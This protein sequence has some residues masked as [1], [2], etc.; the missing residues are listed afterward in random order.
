MTTRWNNASAACVFIKQIR[1]LRP[2]RAA[3]ALLLLGGALG[4]GACATRPAEPPNLSHA[5]TAVLAYVDSGAYARE[6]AAVA[7]EAQAWIEARAAAR[8]PGERLAVVLDID[9]TVLSNLPHLRAQDFGYVPAV[10]EAW[11]ERAEAPALAPMADLFRAARA[12]DVAVLFL[13]GRRD[14]VERAGTEANLRAVGLGDYAALRLTPADAPRGQ[15]ATARKSA[16]RA[17]WA[18]E[19][20]TLIAAIGDQH[21][22]LG[23]PAERSFKLPNPFYFLP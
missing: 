20:W 14:P 8:R 9:E 16:A 2:S 5:K 19:G 11:V 6:F 3:A 22:D 10:W 7:A 13:T 1:R 23:P 18:A 12:Q 21:S 17:A 4:L 15:T